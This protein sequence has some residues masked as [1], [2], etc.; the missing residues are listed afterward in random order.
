MLTP[1]AKYESPDLKKDFIV[2]STVEHTTNGQT[3]GPSDH[4]LQA[5]AVDRDGPSE[6]SKNAMGLLRSQLTTLQDDI[7]V[8]LTERMK[9]QSNEAGL[10]VERRLL[11]EGVDEDS[12]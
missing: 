8:F 5:G 3:T 2:D 4:V 6:A 11:D 10:D 12:D 1:F 9:S 7:N